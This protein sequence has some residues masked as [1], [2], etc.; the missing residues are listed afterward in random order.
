FDFEDNLLV[1]KE[2]LALEED[3]IFEKDLVLKKDQD[4]LNLM[5]V[6]IIKQMFSDAVK[7]I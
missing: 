5:V 4:H 2:D 6:S 3:Q 7:N 1:L